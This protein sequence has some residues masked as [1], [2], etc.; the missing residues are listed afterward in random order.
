MHHHGKRGELTQAREWFN[1]MLA[2]GLA[3]DVV[4]Y[5]TLIHAIV[6]DANAPMSEAFQKVFMVVCMVCLGVI[7]CASE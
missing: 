4:S 2:A 5:N 3:P 6:Q 1:S 7:E